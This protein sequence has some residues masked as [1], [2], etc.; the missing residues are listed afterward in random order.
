VTAPA[1][2]ASSVHMIVLPGGG[3]AE[4]APIAILP[5]GRPRGAVFHALYACATAIFLAGLP[6][7]TNRSAAK[8]IAADLRKGRS[9]RGGQ[10]AQPGAAPSQAAAHSQQRPGADYRQPR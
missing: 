5:N 1:A 9:A 2:A 7:I 6:A 8:A 10:P 4:H 3:Y